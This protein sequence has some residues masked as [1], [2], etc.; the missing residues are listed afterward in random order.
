MRHVVLNLATIR[1]QAHIS[2][3]QSSLYLFHDRVQRSH[4]RSPAEA[5]GGPVI[6]LPLAGELGELRETPG[7]AGI[8]HW[9]SQD[10]GQRGW[11]G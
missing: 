1:G 3:I 2:E 9:G 5:L 7:E 8:L 6:R 10:G 4:H 11:R